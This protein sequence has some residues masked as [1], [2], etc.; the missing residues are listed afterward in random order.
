MN[1]WIDSNAKQPENGLYKDRLPYLVAYDND[2]MMLA[3]KYGE[4][5]LDW[6]TQNE[7]APPKYWMIIDELP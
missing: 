7:I 4:T 1:N 3:Y 2:N 6:E 5:W